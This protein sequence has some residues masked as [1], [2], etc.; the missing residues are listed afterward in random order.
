MNSRETQSIEIVLNGERRQVPGE[1]SVLTLLQSL[2]IEPDRVAIELNREIVRKPD[3]V[4]TAI[5]PGAA[6]EIVQF[7]GGG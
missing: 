1:L 4:K 7:V 3:W 2:G 6:V 5:G